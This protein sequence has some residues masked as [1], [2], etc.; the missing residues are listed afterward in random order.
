MTTAPNATDTTLSEE[1]RQ[2]ALEELRE[3][4]QTRTQ[5]LAAMREWVDQ[6][7]AIIR[8]RTD[9]NFL[10]RFL[11]PKKFSLPIVQEAMTRYLVLRQALPP[12]RRLD[13]EDPAVAALIDKGYVFPSPRR[14]H[15]GRRV[16]I[17]RPGVFDPHQQTNEDMCRIHAMAIEVLL[18]NEED[19]VRGFVHFADGAGVTLPFLTLFT[20]REAVRI[21]KNGERTVP[22]RHK[23][24]YGINV[25]SSLKMALD[26]G[27]GLISEKIRSRIKIFTSLESC[28]EHIDRKLLPKEYGGDIPMDEMIALWKEEL[29]ALRP[30][31]MSHDQMEVNLDMFTEQARS[32]A[33]SAL[34]TGNM[35]VSTHKQDGK[36]D[37]KGLSG[38]FRKL[39]V[40]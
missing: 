27:L 38:S 34:R 23:E 4:E 33:I 28:L 35:L 1:G 31:I 2:I 19:Q 8:C 3:T 25:P 14:D 13:C 30:K 39:E 22:M 20:P 5:A 26:W 7:A 10:L 21:V 12:F 17:Y 32:G 9:D 36:T 37:I 6:N 11:R 15:K 29:R 18:E 24:V 40:D 16:I